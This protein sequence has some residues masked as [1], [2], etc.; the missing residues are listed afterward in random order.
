[1]A[2]T[3]SVGVIICY[4]YCYYSWS[5]SASWILKAVIPPTDV[6]QPREKQRRKTKMERP[7]LLINQVEKGE[8]AHEAILEYS[9]LWQRGLLNVH[10][11]QQEASTRE[12]EVMDAYYSFLVRSISMVICSV[13]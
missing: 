1:M 10:V 5:Q 7:G 4:Y 11:S 12:A 3:V 8:A 6:T 13:S 2:A 9:S